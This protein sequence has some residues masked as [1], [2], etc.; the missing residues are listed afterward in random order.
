ML[1]KRKVRGSN[2]GATDGR[3]WSGIRSFQHSR[4]ASV[5][6]L[7]HLIAMPKGVKK[8]AMPEWDR[9]NQKIGRYD[10]YLKTLDSEYAKKKAKLE[11]TLSDLQAERT[12]LIARDAEQNQM[13]RED[14]AS[15]RA[16]LI[17]DIVSPS[18]DE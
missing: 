4:L 8:Q 12:A 13:Q 18:D 14:A 11:K 7:L 2:P 15:W 10:T 5:V 16:K 1:R 6:V 3:G 9:V 17:A